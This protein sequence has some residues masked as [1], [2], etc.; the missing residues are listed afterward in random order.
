[1]ILMLAVVLAAGIAARAAPADK[2][3]EGLEQRGLKT[4]TKAYLRQQGEE[5]TSGGPKKGPPGEAQMHLAQLAIREARLAENMAARDAAYKQARHFYEQAIAEREKA[6]KAI[7]PARLEKRNDARFN[8][9]KARLELA[10]MIFQQW[11]KI[12]LD[13]LEAGLGFGGDRP[14]VIRLLSLASDTYDATLRDCEEWL[15]TL[16]MLPGEGNQRFT[17]L[18]RRREVTTMMKE[19]KYYNAWTQ[20]YYGWLLPKN[21]KPKKGQRGRKEI[22]NDAITA[23]MPSTDE[24]DRVSA[25]WYAMIGIAMAYRELG[26]Y[27]KAIQQLAK[28]NP[29]PETN[30]RREG[31]WQMGVRIR[32]AY[33]EALTYLAMAEYGKARQVL[34]QARKK[35]KDALDKNLYGL[36]MPIVEAVTYIKEGK[37]KNQ[38]GLEDKG[39]AILKQVHQR[40]NPWPVVV[41]GVMEG[42]VGETPPEE[43]DPFQ[44]WIKANDLM[45]SAQKA[46]DPNEG[47][48]LMKQAADLFKVYADKVGGQDPKYVTALYTR[49]AALVQIGQK[50]E[51]A[52][53]FREVADK[54]PEYKY[55]PEAAKYSVAFAGQAY[56]KAKTEENRQAYEDI[57]RW[58]V[59]KY[60]DSDP[61][62]QYFYALVMY[63][64]EK[65]L[66]AA[67]AFARVPRKAEHF[68]DSKFWIA[69]CRL[70]HFRNK[71]LAS[72]DK[73]LIISSAREVAKE[74]LQYAQYAFQAQ[75]DPHLKPEK[76]QQLL[77][78]AQSAYINAADVYLYQEVSLPADALPILMEAERKFKLSKD[79]LGR[80]LKLKIDAYQ[81][82]NQLERADKELDRFLAVANP[83]DVG[84][85]LGGLFDAMIEEV[86][87]LIKRGQRDLAATKVDAAKKLGDRF[88]QW[89]ANSSLPDKQTEIEN[90]RYDL[91]ELYL[92]VGNYATAL[93][94]YQEIGGPK[95]H[96][97]PADAGDD[98][99]M[100]EA[101]VYG[102]ARAFE[103]L[104]D[105]ATDPAQAKQHYEAALDRWRVLL[106]VADMDPQTRWER[107]YH[108]NYCMYKLGEK[109]AVKK[110][111]IALRIFHEPE[112]LGGSDPVL[113][114]KFR[115]LE[116]A[117]GK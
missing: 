84:P 51:A 101:C 108:H 115:E 75:N 12:E 8:L 52:K 114:K 63:R 64:G 82:S 69:L 59:S 23:F 70:E 44:I 1:M 57:L 58:F 109:E 6:L 90:T 105:Q 10:N 99:L 36:S 71:I 62:A 95:P 16:A 28:V 26:Q 27:P 93:Q 67:D 88:L 7:P 34:A 49:A 113:Q 98:W 5:V 100:S 33:E 48:K 37:A 41:Q 30:N 80:V 20:Y 107:E 56:E 42:L 83:N 39:V 2:F 85:V 111:L 65:F 79:A 45:D 35:F 38:K 11:I 103:H 117:V 94:I 116:D 50:V 15:S 40:D 72:G 74:L 61:D 97:K 54:F 32:K 18:S 29:P 60:L 19:A 24:S 22:L 81:K 86:R 73:N 89:L 4:L 53:L 14:R 110:N 9:I 17:L 78:W 13:L 21:Y 47:A 112:P 25:K 87:D 96:E 106:Q 76:K 66:D 102:Q 92:A 104:G 46:K 31:S 91:A 3:F 55:A 77:D 43:L 68:P